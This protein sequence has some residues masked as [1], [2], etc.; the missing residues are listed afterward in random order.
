MA[1]IR[2]GSRKGGPEGSWLHRMLARKPR[3]VL[4]IARANKIARDLGHAD[5]ERRLSGSCSLSAL[6]HDRTV[7][8]RERRAREEVD[9][10]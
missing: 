2:L 10:R 4:A 3:M 5:E 8:P 1:V 9:E 6:I 7:Q